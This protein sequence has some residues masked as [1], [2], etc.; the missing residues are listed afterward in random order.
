MS[1]Y[2]DLQKVASELLTEFDQHNIVLIQHI[3]DCQNPDEPDESQEVK[4]SLRGVSKGVS[5]FYE[6]SGFVVGSDAIVTTNVLQNVTP[7][8]DDFLE[9]DGILYKILE[10]EPIPRVGVPCV[11]K[12][13]VRKGG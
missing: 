2:S 13:I 8:K 11:W 4:Y 12:F 9:L 5:Q 7:T 3:Y 10:F 6:K 1:V